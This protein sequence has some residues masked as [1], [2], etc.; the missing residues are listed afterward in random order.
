MVTI[1]ILASFLFVPY[2]AKKLDRNPLGYFLLALLLTPVIAILILIIKGRNYEIQDQ[3]EEK[4]VKN[5]PSYIK[6]YQCPQ[7]RSDIN[8]RA[9]ICPFC[10]TK[11]NIGNIETIL[12][13]NE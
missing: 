6:K 12:E 1:F 13:P 3:H 7:C 10:Q 8:R 5:K 4:D 9:K 11:I 2:F